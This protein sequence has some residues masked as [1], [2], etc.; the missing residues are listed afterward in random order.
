M[1]SLEE[2]FFKNIVPDGGSTTVKKLKNRLLREPVVAEVLVSR[3]E[4]IQVYFF[5]RIMLIF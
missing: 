3:H 1:L 5:Y 4:F 2:L